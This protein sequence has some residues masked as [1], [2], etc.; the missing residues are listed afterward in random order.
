MVHED[1]EIALQELLCLEWISR[2]VVRK[3]PAHQIPNSTTLH[4]TFACL[5]MSNPT[6]ALGFLN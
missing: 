4:G 2:V 5:G 1:D 3:V 6:P